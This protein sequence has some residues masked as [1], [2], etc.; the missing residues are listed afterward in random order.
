MNN[1]KLFQQYKNMIESLPDYKEDFD[2][3]EMKI[4]YIKGFDNWLKMNNDFR[5]FDSNL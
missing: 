3:I 4:F 1:N 5:Y 2:N